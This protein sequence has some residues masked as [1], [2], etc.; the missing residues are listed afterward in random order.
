MLKGGPWTFDNQVLLMH[1]WQ[2]GMITK[3]VQFDTIS[4]WVQIW[5]APFDMACPKVVEEVG[6]RIGEVEEVEKR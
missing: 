3:N 1:K 2:V 6:R 5:G 4:L